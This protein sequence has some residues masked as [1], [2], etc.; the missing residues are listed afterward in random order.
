VSIWSR[1]AYLMKGRT[2]GKKIRVGDRAKTPRRVDA[3]APG[4]AVPI[5]ST[6]QRLGKGPRK[7]QRHAD[8]PPLSPKVT[9]RYVAKDGPAPSVS[10]RSW[11]RTRIHGLRRQCGTTVRIE[12]PPPDLHTASQHHLDTNSEDGAHHLPLNLPNL[13][14]AGISTR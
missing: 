12:D 7:L 9:R 14:L 8:F 2:H 5:S 10:P 4:R 3:I 13:C 1:T 6:R 11:S